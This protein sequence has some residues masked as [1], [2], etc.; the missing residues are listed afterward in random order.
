MQ[1]LLKS[2]GAAA[3]ERGAPEGA[4]KC[5]AGGSRRSVS[6]ALKLKRL[7]DAELLSLPSYMALTVWA[8]D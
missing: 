5:I 7:G 3:D 8:P 1:G 4:P 2:Q 6:A